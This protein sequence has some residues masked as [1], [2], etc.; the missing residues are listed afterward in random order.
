MERAS[1]RD[2]PQYERLYRMGDVLKIECAERLEYEVE[3]TTHVIAHGPRHAH[4]TRRAFGLKSRRDVHRVPVQ[5]RCY[6]IA[7]IDPYAKP[8]SSV[9]GLVPIMKWDLLLCLHGKAHGPIYAVE[10]DQQGVP[11]GL[12]DPTA[13]LFDRRIN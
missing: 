4:A 13:M 6:G 9:G 8:N 1:G 2:G 5:V 3:P 7:K 12:Y 11:T 10:Y